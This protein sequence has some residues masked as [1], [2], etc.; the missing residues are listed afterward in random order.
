MTRACS[1]SARV[2]CASA[3]ESAA[4][5]WAKDENVKIVIGGGRDA[6]RAAT[7][8]AAAGV[9]V[10]LDPV[11]GLPTRTD[12]PYDAP[13]AAPG[14]LSKAG[15]RVAIPEGDSQFVRNLANHA[16]VATAYGMPRDRAL[17]AINSSPRDLG[18]A[19]RVGRGAR[20]D[21]TFRVEGDVPN[22]Q[23]E[24]AGSTAAR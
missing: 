22:S 19:D 9:P 8:L 15:V 10:V 13:Y 12:E 17:A 23:V 18:I 20:K 14:I 5:A 1:R 24:A 16:S 7:E 6:W 21:A 3:S 4:L 11:I 2:A